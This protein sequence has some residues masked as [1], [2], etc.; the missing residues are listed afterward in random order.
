M[1]LDTK[2]PYLLNLWHNNVFSLKSKTVNLTHL[3]LSAIKYN[4]AKTQRY[5]FMGNLNNDLGPKNAIVALF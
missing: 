1:I 2:M 3:S 4:F 5:R